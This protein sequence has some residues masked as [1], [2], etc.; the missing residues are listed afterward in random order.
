M[1]VIVNACYGGFSLSDKAIELLFEKKRWNLVKEVLDSGFTSYYKDSIGENN[2]FYEGDLDRNDPELVAVVE[3]LGDEANGWPAELK[4]I[5]IPDDVE[6]FVQEY[7][8]LEWI[9]EKHRT[10]K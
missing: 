1:K 9:A 7:D 2:F 6:W 4:I 3:E 10:W 5:D 8:G